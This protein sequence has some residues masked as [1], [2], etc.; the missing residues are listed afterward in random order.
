METYN[1]TACQASA[2]AKFPAVD[3]ME[4]SREDGVP[5]WIRFAHLALNDRF[6]AILNAKYQ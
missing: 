4:T 6:T 2:K 1:Y 3:V 5:A